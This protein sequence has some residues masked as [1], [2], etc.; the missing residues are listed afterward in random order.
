M[1]KTSNRH[2][3][4]ADDRFV[5]AL[6][7]EHARLGSGDDLALLALIRARTEE[8]PESGHKTS[9]SQFGLRQWLQVAAVV[10]I[11]GI[12]LT[13]AFRHF[14]PGGSS[15]KANQSI[16]TSAGES[17]SP[18][19]DREPE[20]TIRIRNVASLASN[21]TPH[22][23]DSRDEIGELFASEWHSPLIQPLSTIANPRD[24]ASASS[25]TLSLDQIHHLLAAA[26]PLPAGAVTVSSLLEQLPLT[27][28]ESESNDGALYLSAATCPWNDK[29]QLIH[30]QIDSPRTQSAFQAFRDAGPKSEVQLPVFLPLDSHL[31][32]STASLSAKDHEIDRELIRMALA[33]VSEAILGEPIS[34]TPQL[35][36]EFNPA[37]ASHYR[38]LGYATNFEGRLSALYE[39]R[40]ADHAKAVSTIQD[41]DLKYQPANASD[42]LLTARHGDDESSIARPQSSA[43]HQADADLQ[44]SAAAAL[45]AKLVNSD[46]PPSREGIGLLTRLLNDAAIKSP[47]AERLRSIISLWAQGQY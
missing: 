15:S 23:I 25:G 4:E 41:T 19:N 10:T 28:P 40:N 44:V 24:G 3:P 16:A 35:V 39:I 30:V 9:S 27:I 7:E 1:A 5:E 37:R 22:S 34:P 17:P 26:K 20:Y 45:F 14:S 13:V 2:L 38:L 21:G 31:P 33:R 43:W 32:P 18:G 8:Q 46:Q 12:V 47:Q 42:D 11:I 36:I 6:L 29:H